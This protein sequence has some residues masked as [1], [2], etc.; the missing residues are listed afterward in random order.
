MDNFQIRLERA[1]E[2]EQDMI[3]AL[4]VVGKLPLT[5]AHRVYRY[6]CS[7]ADPVIVAGVSQAVAE[8]VARELRE[9]GAAVRIEPCSLSTPMVVEPKASDIY[10]WTPGRSL[11]KQGRP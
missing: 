5:R 10:A 8:H 7:A 11:R 1:A 4:R 3:K 2:D 6:L 9:S